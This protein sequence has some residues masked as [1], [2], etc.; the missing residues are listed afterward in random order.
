MT[1]TTM[2]MTMTNNLVFL[3]QQPT[4]VGCIPARGVVG[5]LYDDDEDEVDNDGGDNEDVFD[6]DV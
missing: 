2:K 4:L 5:D 1:I 3:R 6:E